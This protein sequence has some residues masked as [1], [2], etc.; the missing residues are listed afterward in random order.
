MTE[1]VGLAVAARFVFT[2]QFWDDYAVVCRAVEN[3]PGTVVAQRFGLFKTWTEANAFAR[4][5]NEGLDIDPAEVR[6]I[7]SKC[8]L[9]RDYVVHSAYESR[10]PWSYS[11]VH[12][13]N[14]VARLNFLRREL[15]LA[16]TFCETARRGLR[17]NYRAFRNARATLSHVKLFILCFDGDPRELEDIATAAD[18]LA[19]LLHRLFPSSPQQAACRP[20]LHALL[21]SSGSP[22]PLA[23]ANSAP[24]IR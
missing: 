6:Q 4:K 5:L 7:V 19:A 14:H 12:V 22:R 15:A 2:A 11:P 23:C 3:Q 9:L 17:L 20:N 8:L 16:L 13:H 21:R 1:S 18:D 10:H 24:G